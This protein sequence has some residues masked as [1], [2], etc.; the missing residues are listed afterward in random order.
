MKQTDQDLHYFIL[1]MSNE[2]R[3]SSAAANTWLI[4]KTINYHEQTQTSV[5]K[6]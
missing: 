3:P 5:F 6:F 2:I 4:S 1:A